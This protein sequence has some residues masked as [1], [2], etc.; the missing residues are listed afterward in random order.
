MNIKEKLKQYGIWVIRVIWQG[1]RKKGTQR[2]GI[3]VLGLGLMF[4]VSQASALRRTIAGIFGAAASAQ[5][6]TIS[7]QRQPVSV[8]NSVTN[9]ATPA[10]SSETEPV[11]NENSGPVNIVDLIADSETIFR[12]AVKEVTDGFENGVPYTQVTLQVNEALRGQLGEE[13][14]FRQFG[15]MQPRKMDN[16]KTYLGVTPEGWSKYAVGDDAMFFLFKPASK[17]GLRTTVGLGQG[18]VNFRG[19]NAESQFAN[20]GMFDNVE[21]DGK[22][23]NDRDKRLLA[24]KKGALMPKVPVVRASCRK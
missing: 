6:Q 14:T 18:K 16:G 19:G 8:Q 20:E 7:D 9:P 2:F 3:L 10:V 22:L 23:L 5:R 13:Y 21:V 11:S 4:A 15:L 1:W 24:T 12:G 17:T